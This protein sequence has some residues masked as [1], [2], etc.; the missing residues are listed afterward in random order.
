MRRGLLDSD[1]CCGDEPIE[2][3]F[4]LLNR[5]RVPPTLTLSETRN[6]SRSV[7]Q[8]MRGAAMGAPLIQPA[9]NRADTG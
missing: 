4:Q 8:R 2:E 1:S 5:A 6:G 7:I 9:T 3:L